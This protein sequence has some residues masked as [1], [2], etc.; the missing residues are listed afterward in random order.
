[1]VFISYDTWSGAKYLQ[2]RHLCRFYW[3]P[4][5]SELMQIQY[6]LRPAE[7][8]WVDCSLRIELTVSATLTLSPLSFNNNATSFT[9]ALTFAGGKLLDILLL[10]NRPVASIRNALQYLGVNSDFCRQ[11]IASGKMIFIETHQ[12][13]WRWYGQRWTLEFERGSL[14]SRG[15]S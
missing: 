4:A 15:R 14:R 6:L 9:I 5:C 3:L 11:L 7:V 13:M 2:S 10:T 1:M 12:S 8:S